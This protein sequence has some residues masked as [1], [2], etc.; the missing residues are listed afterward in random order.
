ML[1]RMGCNR[2]R[3]LSPLGTL[4][5]VVV[6]DLVGGAAMR[7]NNIIPT[8]KEMSIQNETITIDSGWGIDNRSGH[9]DIGQR[10]A[11]ELDLPC[12]MRKSNVTLL[13]NDDLRPEEYRLDIAREDVSIMA[14]INW[15][16]NRVPRFT[17]SSGT[18]VRRAGLVGNKQ[19]KKPW[20]E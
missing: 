8:P 15:P 1:V 2:R 10:Y 20:R 6:G 5:L 3:N 7:S 17:I 12:S 4:D 11:E 13:R 9:P 18:Q 19:S 16:T 14:A